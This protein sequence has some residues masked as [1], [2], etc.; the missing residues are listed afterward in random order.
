MKARMLGPFQGLGSCQ[1]TA[2]SLIARIFAK[3]RV[4]RASSKTWSG[5]VGAMSVKG[6]S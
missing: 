2:A 4:T 6:G 3:S 5:P 1:A